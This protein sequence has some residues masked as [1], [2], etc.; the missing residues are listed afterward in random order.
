MRNREIRHLVSI[1]AL[2]LIILMTQSLAFGAGRIEHHQIKSEVM[3]AV[4]DITEREL[5]VYLPEEYNMSEL[6]YPVLYL[7]HGA[8]GLN[9]GNNRLY[10]GGSYVGNNVKYNVH[11]SAD[12]LFEDQEAQPLIIV[13]PDMNR[14]PPR[15]L[16]SFLSIAGDYMALEIVPFIDNRYR[17]ISSRE[18]R[19]ISGHSDGA[20][21]ASFI[22]LAR[23]DVFSLAG[24][25][26][27]LGA[28]NTSEIL[29]LARDHDQELLP[30][31]FFILGMKGGNGLAGAAGLISALE[32]SNIPCV[33]IE[34]DGDHYQI[35]KGLEENIVLFSAILSSAI[36]SIQPHSRL[37]MTWGY[38][39][40]GR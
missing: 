27:G 22:G 7:L 39:K 17:T 10:F 1:N 26:D 15:R 34:H 13:C 18:G 28:V 23:S 38:V 2:G 19:A 32:K 3:A 11:L 36:V 6:A 20:T 14:R 12:R 16:E 30:L 24:L 31:Q 33:K 35:T 21:G 40:R 37:A 9:W 4:G 5:S 25:L 29:G 8:W